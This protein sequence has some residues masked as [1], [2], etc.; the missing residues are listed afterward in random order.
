[1]NEPSLSDKSTEHFLVS[2]EGPSISL[3]SLGFLE[4]TVFFEGTSFTDFPLG[5]TWCL[6]GPVCVTDLDSPVCVCDLE[7]AVCVCD[8]EGAVCVCDLDTFPLLGDFD[9]ESTP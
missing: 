4:L 5:V 3:D 7:G 6:I 9:L 2:E 1:M 8:L